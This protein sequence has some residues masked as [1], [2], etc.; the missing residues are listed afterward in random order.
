M[1]LS[2]LEPGD[3]FRFLDADS[4]IRYDSLYMVAELVSPFTV[5]KLPSLEEDTED[6]TFESHRLVFDLCTGH[7]MPFKS[8]LSVIPVKHLIIDTE[9]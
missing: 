1:L 2:D 9:S 4:T 7:A 8:H 3:C 5:S 6:I